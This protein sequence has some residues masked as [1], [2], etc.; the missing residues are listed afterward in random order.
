MD[1]DEHDNLQLRALLARVA[2]T[3]QDNI[4]ASD[5]DC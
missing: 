3:A 1:L 2:R 4:T 5:V